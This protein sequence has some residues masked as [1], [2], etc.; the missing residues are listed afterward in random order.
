LTA[1]VVAQIFGVRKHKRLRGKLHT[2]LEKVDHG[3]HVLRI[4]CKSLVARM[5]EKFGTFLRIEV[6]VNRLQDLGL[7]KGLDQLPALRRKLVAITDRLA[8][9][10]SEFLNVHVDFPVFERLAKPVAT[11]ATKIPGIKIHDTRM[12][13]VMEVLLHGGSQLVG[14]R[15]ADMHRA[16]R[17]AFCDRPRRVFAHPTPL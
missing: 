6:C 17:E 9:V 1:D 2:M 5:Y 12:L 16:V 3:H 14:W 10:E 8:G 7:K 11:G 4:Y 13:R 15:T